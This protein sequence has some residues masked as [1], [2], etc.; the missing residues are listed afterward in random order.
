MGVDGR[1]VAEVIADFSNGSQER[2]SGFLLRA[3]VLLTAWHVVA[4]ADRVRAV[5][6]AG[7]DQRRTAMMRSL[8]RIG[9]SD[10][11]VVRLD[12]LPRDATAIPVGG[13]GQGAAVVGVEA[14]GFPR[15]KI[16]NVDGTNP[17]PDDGKKKFRELAQ[18]PA[19]LAPQGNWRTGR[20]ELIVVSPDR[21]SDPNRSAWE[22][23]SGAPVFDQQSGMLVA[24]VT[25]HHRP[26]GL[27]R[28]AAARLDACLAA[29]PSDELALLLPILGMES[30][31]RL[32]MAGVPPWIGRK[33][34]ALAD[35]LA[36]IVPAG[37]LQARDEELAELTA[38]CAG[39]DSYSFWQAPPWAGKTALM[40]TFAQNPPAGVTVVAYFVTA[41]QS[42]ENDSTGFL[43]AVSA[44]L[45]MLMGESPP[46]IMTAREVY[47]TFL[48][49]R[50]RQAR[51]A[52]HQL[53]LLVDG[54]D[55]DTGTRAGSGLPSIAS[56]LPRK[57]LPGLKVIVAGR[58]DPKL[59]ADLAPDHILRSCPRRV[60]R[61]S[62]YAAEIERA[63]RLELMEVLS[64]GG[65][66][67]DVVGLI[68]A[69]EGGLSLSDLEQLA[70]QPKDVLEDLLGSV[71]GR[72]IRGR[73]AIGAAT[74]QHAYL[75][76]HDTLREQAFDILGDNQLSSYRQPL[77]RWADEYRA[78]GWPTATPRYLLT[79]YQKMLA[80]TVDV[81]RLAVLAQDKARHDRML[82]VHGGDDTAYSEI[83]AALS[84]LASIDEANLATIVQIARERDRLR[85]RNR[86]VPFHLPRAWAMLG[87][88]YR[89]EALARSIPNPQTQ[90]EMLVELVET[91][92]A[93]DADRARQLGVAAE[94][95]ARTIPDS[96][97]QH[98]ALV[99]VAGALAAAD[100][101]GAEQIARSIPDS[102]EQ[103]RALMRIH[104]PPSSIDRARAR[105]LTAAIENLTVT[106]MSEYERVEVLV[107]LAE[108][109]AATDVDRAAQLV[110]AAEQI[111][112]RILHAG[113]RTEAM[114]LLVRAVTV[115]N[116]DWARRLAATAE[117][118]VR[119]NPDSDQLFLP[120]LRLV[121]AV[122]L[123]DADRAERIA[124]SLTYMAHRMEAL[125]R[126]AGAVVATDPEHARQV[127]AVAERML[128]RDWPHQV[129]YFR[130]RTLLDLAET[131][132]AVDRD[133]SGHFAAAAEQ[134]AV[135]IISEQ[136]RAEVL[137][138][139]VK[140]VGRLDAEAVN[141]I[142][143]A[144]EQAARSVR[145]PEYRSHALAVLV[146][147]MA[148]I[149]HS[150][151]E[152]IA[153]SI[154]DP[155]YRAQSLVSVVEAIAGFDGDR[156]KQLANMAERTARTVTHPSYRTDVLTRLAQVLAVIDVDRAEGVAR[157][158]DDLH[159][160]MRM[161]VGLVAAVA[162]V[163]F[164][165]ADRIAQSIIHPIYRTQAL[166]E[167]AC[168]LATSDADRA[169]RIVRGISDPDFQAHAL[170]RLVEALTPVDFS[171]ARRLAAIATRAINNL[172][173]RD[174]ELRA[175]ARLA[176]ALAPIDTRRAAHIVLNMSDSRYRVQAI[177][178][179]VSALAT[180]DTD[181]A[182]QITRRISDPTDQRHAWLVLIRKLASVNPDRA[183]HI[184]CR[185]VDSSD[186]TLAL[187]ELAAALAPFDPGRAEQI[188]RDI[189][190]SRHRSR[191]LAK[192]SVRGHRMPWQDPHSKQLAVES[193]LLGGSW[194]DIL[195]ALPPSALTMICDEFLER[196][197]PV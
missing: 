157:C 2:G 4:G 123:F 143:N 124:H 5:F 173:N 66:N 109:L 74:P 48:A 172:T 107:W 52:G 21:D 78:R 156:A 70:G 34:Q 68:A 192:V 23:M 111:S 81:Q 101:D 141:R 40:A 136:H 27:S 61:V 102:Y 54:L 43:R 20:C 47:R 93:T 122:A 35:E 144:A 104:D 55:E 154:P 6:E 167:L 57:P 117:Q 135:E 113:A 178:G 26:E 19:V 42:G 88:S 186:R 79:G 99:T 195:E 130:A 67:R 116:V 169:E 77:H 181:Y 53:L 177:T 16:R 12:R 33:Q 128:H 58:P 158:V 165:R 142:A 170:I 106:I 114:A 65:I 139:I 95:V 193:I 161:L 152:Q 196:D 133:R 145:D 46:T 121:E 159:G 127:A 171:R 71:F 28:L 175:L 174:D 10:V 62:P 92:A 25:D 140:V 49:E 112:R 44:Q 7:S 197:P 38:F 155:D 126:L 1:R 179:M 97:D 150:R 98:R 89:A 176:A 190:A 15:F 90:T 160:Q 129:S 108:A 96:I 91:V 134:A 75:F 60:L 24:V 168:A 50:A 149:D 148:S 22:G 45:A 39:S 183:V 100:P 13:F 56:L 151:A 32:P 162:P 110:I 41:R 86:D 180:I 120:V 187:G 37:G 83:H 194:L 132:S 85:Q 166:A 182:E 64:R 51:A 31:D 8:I 153:Y 103:A 82:E 118:V 189:P 87:Q 59:P 125:V 18:V 29:L 17:L 115:L 147:A 138:R 73:L 163:D 131:F 137:V 84:H 36:E 191:A 80:A 72:T 164:N 188:A 11:A 14:F 30:A 146:E 184:A 63:A 94:Q 3:D 119:A 9:S 105:Q 185:I 76:S 69:S